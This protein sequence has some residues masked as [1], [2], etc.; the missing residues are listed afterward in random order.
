MSIPRVGL[1][2]AGNSPSGRV[3]SRV[4]CLINVYQC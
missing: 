1:V 3:G 4:Y 2:D